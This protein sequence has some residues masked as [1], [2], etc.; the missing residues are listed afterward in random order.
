MKQKIRSVE[1]KVP[2]SF[3]F[4]RKQVFLYAYK[5]YNRYISI[6]IRVNNMIS[7]AIMQQIEEPISDENDQILY[8][9]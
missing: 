1:Q 8:K 5:K 3:D 6:S 2:V 9:K 7:I 4:R